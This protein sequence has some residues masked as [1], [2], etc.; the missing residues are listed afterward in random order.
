MSYYQ[1]INRCNRCGFCQSVCPTYLE[2]HD[3]AQLARGRIY[4]MRMLLEGRFDFTKDQDVSE[5]VDDCLLCRACVCNCPSTVRTD[6]V[7]MTARHDFVEAR[8]I[9][10]FQKLVYRGVLSHRERLDRTSFLMRM[11][12]KSGVR[13]L[14]HQKTL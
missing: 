11:Y 3:E 6:A 14:L 7:M 2:T 4:L 5:K 8:G 10:L 1:E 9:S 13:N 12:E